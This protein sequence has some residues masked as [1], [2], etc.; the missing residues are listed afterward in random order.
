MALFG[1]RLRRRSR[2][3]VQERSYQ[4][5]FSCA[6]EAAFGCN[7]EARNEFCGQRDTLFRARNAVRG[8]DQ[9]QVNFRCRRQLEIAHRREEVICRARGRHGQMNISNL[10]F[11]VSCNRVRHIDEMAR[12]HRIEEV[13]AAEIAVA[14]M[15]A[16]LDIIGHRRT[17]ASE[18]FGNFLLRGINKR[19]LIL[20]LSIPQDHV[21]ADIPLDA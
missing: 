9:A 17:D 12:R 3:N 15:K 7:P 5:F 1:G 10:M 20:R 13:L 18:A 11:D 14:K 21:V 8:V 19:K 2:V 4:V 16:E 6:G